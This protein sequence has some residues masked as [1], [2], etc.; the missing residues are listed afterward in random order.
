[1][2]LTNPSNLTEALAAGHTV[3]EEHEQD[4]ALATFG[5][6]AIAQDCSTWPPGHKC[7]ETDCIDGWKLVLYCDN[8]KGC[9]VYVKT[10]C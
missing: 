4:D 7:G 2:A 10:P 8:T 9:T 5:A 3:V 6:P 1:V